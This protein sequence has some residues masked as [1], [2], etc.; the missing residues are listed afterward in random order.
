MWEWL[1][2]ILFILIVWVRIKRR[3]YFWKA[4]DGVELTLKQFF[5]RWE[6]GIEGITPLQQ[7]FTQLLGIWIVISGII[8]GIVVNLLVQMKDVWWW[9]TIIL[10]GSLII[11]VMQL[12]G[13]YQSYKR[14]KII[15]EQMRKLE[16]GLN[17]KNT[18][19]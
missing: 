13:T 11:T 17:E 19:A 18:K 7:K 10:V 5:K 6:K 1:I 15:D 16:G 8:A 9:V 12:I 2:V 3:N 14:Y 4:R